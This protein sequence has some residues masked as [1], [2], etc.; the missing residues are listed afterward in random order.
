MKMLWT[1]SDAL[2]LVMYPPSKKRKYIYMFCLRLYA[3]LSDFFVQEHLI[4]HEGLRPALEKFKMKKPITVRE[5]LYDTTKYVKKPHKL[6]N[7]LFFVR[8]SNNQPYADWIY[9]KKYYDFLVG[10]TEWFPDHLNVILV[11][12]SSD[13]SE[14]YPITDCYIKINTTKYNGLNRIGKECL[15]NDIPV[16]VV[17]ES[18]G[19]NNNKKT[20]MEFLNNVKKNRL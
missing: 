17:N 5:D 20:I 10:Y 14:I 6:L 15:N 2:F 12:G 18:D 13:M 9:G 11:D 16:L 19:F 4:N 8:K 7:I 1:G 3:R